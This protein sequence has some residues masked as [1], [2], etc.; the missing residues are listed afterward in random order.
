MKG[1]EMEDAALVVYA[2]NQDQVVPCRDM[3]GLSL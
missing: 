1:I 2:M 3:R